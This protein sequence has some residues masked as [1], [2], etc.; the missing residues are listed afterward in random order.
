MKGMPFLHQEQK[1][2]RKSLFSLYALKLPHLV[3]SV[4]QWLK[5]LDLELRKAV[6]PWSNA[7]ARKIIRTTLIGK[8]KHLR[9]RLR[10][11]YE[12]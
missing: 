8:P 3:A 5:L 1:A 4:L 6:V 12:K 10:Y 7:V 11:K 9:V 2:T